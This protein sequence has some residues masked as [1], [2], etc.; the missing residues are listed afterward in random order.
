MD[1]FTDSEYLRDGITEWI[2]AWKA[3]GWRTVDKKPVKNEDLWR[4]L[5]ALAAR[6]QIHWQW[7]KG[8]AGHPLN[9]RC[10]QLARA[11]IGQIR[12]EFTPQQLV[13][14]LAEFARGRA[15][16]KDQ[17]GLFE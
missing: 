4:E 16:R 13:A 10:D 1:L 2:G 12:K 5:E 17:I 14:Q 15:P 9:E 3:R 7:Q 11:A 8:H 6:H